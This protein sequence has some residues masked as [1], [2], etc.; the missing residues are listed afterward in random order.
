MARIIC[1]DTA[2]KSCSVAIAEDGK[3]VTSEILNSQQYSHAENLHLMMEKVLKKAGIPSSDLHA[4]AVSE[5]PGSYT[6]L[7]I[8][9]SAAKGLCYALNIP[10]IAVGTLRLMCEDPEVK[11]SNAD[12]YIPMIDARRN[13]VYTAVFSADGSV[14]KPIEAVVLDEHPFLPLLS[15]KRAIFFGDGAPKFQSQISHPNASFS[16]VVNPDAA[17]MGHLA[18]E[19][20]QRKE[21]ENLAYYEPFYLK[22]FQ[23]GKPKNQL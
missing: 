17:Y 14:V 20:Y 19:K 18:E 10:L 4:V 3:C 13:E 12:L 9:I 11:S 1:I 2:T 15:E 21:I 5:G 16:E 23:A 6:G 8:G 22:E 7:R